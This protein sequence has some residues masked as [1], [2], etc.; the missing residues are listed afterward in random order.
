MHDQA[1]V[2]SVLRA[3]SRTPRRTKV[4]RRARFAA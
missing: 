1:Y 4:A 2:R 3:I